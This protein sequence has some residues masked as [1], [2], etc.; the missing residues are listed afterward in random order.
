MVKLCMEITKYKKYFCGE[1]Q[2]VNLK[3]IFITSSPLVYPF[4]KAN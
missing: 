3:G 4:L 2:N 1:I